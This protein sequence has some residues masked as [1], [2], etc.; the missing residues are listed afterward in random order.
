MKV[1]PV[2]IQNYQQT[3][4]R[5]EAGKPTARPEQAAA[6]ATLGIEPQKELTGSKL[7]IKAPSSTY[8]DALSPQEREALDLL[9]AKF[10]DGTRFGPSY[11]AGDEGADEP[12]VGRVIDVK[13]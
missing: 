9:F 7:A 6:R 10:R 3:A 5:E 1:N 12:T 2:S 4:R 8:A 13:V 11:G